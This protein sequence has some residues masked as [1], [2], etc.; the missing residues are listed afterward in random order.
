VGTNTTHMSIWKKSVRGALVGLMLLLTGAAPLFTVAVDN[1]N[2]DETPPITVEF[3][4]D[5]PS[6]KAFHMHVSEASL[7]STATEQV[8]SLST[9]SSTSQYQPTLELETSLPQLVV[10]LRT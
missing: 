8:E 3:N 10:P 1:D 6:R 9:A 4:L 7:P 2:D 5:A